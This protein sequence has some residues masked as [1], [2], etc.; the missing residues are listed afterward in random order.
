MTVRD[1]ILARSN[2]RNAIV[3]DATGVATVYAGDGGIVVTC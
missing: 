3:V 1:M 2:F